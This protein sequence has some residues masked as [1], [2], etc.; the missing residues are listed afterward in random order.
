MWKRLGAALLLRTIARELR[1]IREQLTRQGDL[2]ERWALQAGL[3]PSQTSAAP[4]EADTGISF[5]DPIEQ[6][7]VQDYIEK[8]ERDTGHVPT[9]DQ[10]LS[11]LADERT[12]SLHSRLREREAL[13]DLARLGRR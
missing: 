13:A 12:V 4:P 5:L 8:T 1:G 3:Q 11:Y 6:G 9:D 10:I 7:I 2:L